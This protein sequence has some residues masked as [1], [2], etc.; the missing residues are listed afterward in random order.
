MMRLGPKKVKRSVLDSC[1]SFQ[2]ESLQSA[3]SI[4]KRAKEH[5]F[6]CSW[7]LLS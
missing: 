3:R 6:A 1:L 4:V 7:I 2:L 5:I